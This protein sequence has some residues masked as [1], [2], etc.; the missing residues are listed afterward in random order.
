MRTTYI[1]AAA[2]SRC[3]GGDPNCNVCH[4]PV[5]EEIDNDNDNDDTDTDTDLETHE[6]RGLAYERKLE[7]ADFLRDQGRDEQDFPHNEQN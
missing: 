7:H 4:D 3:G 1:G 6:G 2:C 5:E